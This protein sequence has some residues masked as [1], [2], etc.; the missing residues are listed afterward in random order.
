[1]GDAL[2]C[3]QGEKDTNR[4]QPNREGKDHKRHLSAVCNFSEVLV[5]DSRININTAREEELM[6][7]PGI[8]RFLA[9]N[10]VVYREKIGGFR[11]VEDAALVTG[12]GATKLQLIKSEICVTRGDSSKAARNLSSFDLVSS[13]KLNINV[14]SETQL[15][16]VQGVSE[17]L[18]NDIVLYRTANGP[19]AHVDHLLR[20]PGVD[21]ALLNVIQGKLTVSLPRPASSNLCLGGES[22]SNLRLSFYSLQHL[23]LEGQSQ[24]S[25]V[26][27]LLKP[28]TGQHNGRPVVRIGSWNLQNLTLDKV[29]N[30]GVREVICLTLLEN[31]YICLELEKPT[32]ATVQEWTGDRGR[33]KYVVLDTPMG[34][35]KEDGTSDSAV[36]PL[37][38]GH[39][40]V[41][42]SHRLLSVK[43]LRYVLREAAGSNTMFLSC[44]SDNKHL[45]ILG[46]FGLQPDAR[47]FDVL[48]EN[49]FHHCIPEDI[50][51]NISTKAEVGGASQ[52][53]IWWNEQ[54]Q[55]THTGR[56]GVIRQGLSSP[57]IPDG[58][59][60]GGV[61]SEHCPVWTEIFI[62]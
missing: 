57:W 22:R 44:L 4:R 34:E 59:K 18:A 51:T 29:N 55:G 52:D 43:C 45:V 14:A 32:I 25:L 35:P 23:N 27:P 49:H 19:F 50:F 30:P 3:H 48:R 61:V 9:H 31:G 7:L 15:T 41:D 1:M 13:T 24:T 37:W 54:A 47:E 60:W 20:V 2:S 17:N 12:V 26:R 46:H 58:W 6:T 16:A 39:W 10:I 62:D 5:R 36:L 56:S 42:E 33:W 38:V 11:K 28:F 21:V 53:N 8:T 40:S